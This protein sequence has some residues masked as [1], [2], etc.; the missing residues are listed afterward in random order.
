MSQLFIIL[1]TAFLLLT[2]TVFGQEEDFSTQNYTPSVL[3]NQNQYEIKFFNT[4]YT[5]NKFFNNGGTTINEASRSTYFTSTLTTMFGTA[6][7]VNIGG[8]IWLK[9][10]KTFNNNPFS[11]LH[12]FDTLNSRT[13]ITNLG[14]KVKLNPLKKW[15]RLSVQS[16]FLYATAQHYNKQPYLT[17]AHHLFITDVL[18]DKVLSNKFSL[19][20]QLSSWVTIAAQA[21]ENN[22]LA[23]PTTA[24]LTFFANQKLSLYWQN[25]FWP[26]WASNGINSY[27][28]QEGI[29][30]KYQ[31]FSGFEAETLF[32]SFV[33]G[34][35]TGAGKTIN[36]GFRFI[37]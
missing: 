25:Q 5:Q 9:S 7:N 31:F 34:K 23:T 18:Y 6:K 22:G 28:L 24:I 36:L 16:A 27:Y 4:I 10:V 13:A 26:N 32:S 3:L 15:D 2:H 1:F 20:T 37:H 8:E 19:F 21:T 30:I 12:F 29:G 17:G 14:I 35:Q 33:L 11:V